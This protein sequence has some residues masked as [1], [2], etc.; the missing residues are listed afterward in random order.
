MRKC[1]IF[2]AGALALAGCAEPT[3][4]QAATERYGYS[5]QAIE[6]NRYRVSFAG[7]SVTPR[8][9]VETYLL[10]RAAEVTRANGGD[11]FRVADRDTE[12]NT[13]YRTASFPS[14]HFLYGSRFFYRFDSFYVS[15]GQ[16]R[17]IKR[18][19]AFADILV[20]TGEKPADDAQAYDARDLIE[21]LGPS[22]VRPEAGKAA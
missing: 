10:Y 18:Y 17:S 22:V 4:Y 2:L 15:G 13:E 6:S 14:S 5:D 3:A 21:K 7:N 12:V 1:I 20:L 8:E 19:K 11:Y 9:T 16:S